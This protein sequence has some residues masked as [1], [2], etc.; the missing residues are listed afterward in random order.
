MESVFENGD[1]LQLKKAHACGGQYWQVVRV[2][3]DI[4]LQ[5]K[6]CGRFLNFT[7]DDLKKSVKTRK[8]SSGE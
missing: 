4:K 7:R 3:V 2:G 8:P 1:T 5:C 6:T